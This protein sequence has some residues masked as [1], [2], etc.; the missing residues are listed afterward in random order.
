MFCLDSEIKITKNIYCCDCC[1]N[2][3]K[4]C[5]FLCVK[6]EKMSFFSA[7]I[8]EVGYKYSSLR[9]LWL[10]SKINKCT[11]GQRKALVNFL[12]SSIFSKFSSALLD[13]Y[14][15]DLLRNQENSISEE[16]IREILDKLCVI[17]SHIIDLQKQYNIWCRCETCYEKRLSGN[18]AAEGMDNQSTFNDLF[19]FH[20]TLEDLLG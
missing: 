18:G 19:F 8:F 7:S 9:F 14:G 20:H 6:K 10:T 17:N 11:P 4:N 1:K 13:Q 5:G 12:F 3:L 15:L 16:Y 2:I